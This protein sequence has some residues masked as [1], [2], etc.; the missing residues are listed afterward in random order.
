MPPKL[1]ILAGG[2]RLP[3]LLDQYCARTGRDRLVIVFD[4]QGD[5]AAFTGSPVAVNRLGAAGRTLSLLRDAGCREI[6]MAGGMRRPPLAALWPDWWAIRFLLRTRAF[7][8]GD[9]GLLRALIGGIEREGFR[10]VGVDELLPELVAG[11]GAIGAVQPTEKELIDVRAAVAAART[12]GRADLGQ[13]AVARDGRTVDEEDRAGTDAMLARVADGGMPGR[14]GV[15]AKIMKPN[16]ERRADLPA[17][18]PETVENARKAG[19]AGIAVEAGNA[20]ILDREETV[21]RA[22]A[23]GLFLYGVKV[24]P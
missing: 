8:R 2:G 19:L 3:I 7:G 15:L 20:L 12:L 18:G 21:R 9:D 10:V 22:D 13:A 11:E 6:V 1:G 24:A 23:A 4:G 17:I 5:P 14:R 16:Q